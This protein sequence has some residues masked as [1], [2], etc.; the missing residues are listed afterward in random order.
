MKNRNRNEPEIFKELEQLCSSPGYIHAIAYFCFRDNVIKY[1]LGK[2]TSEDFLQQS[3]M[4]KLIRTEISTLIGLACKNSIDKELQLPEITQ[5]YIDQTEALLLELHRSMVSSAHKLFNPLSDDPFANGTILREAIFYGGESAYH[6]QY[7]DFSALK[8]QN[9]NQ[10]LVAN[11]GFY[12]EQAIEI[13]RAIETIQCTKLNNTHQLLSE[14]HPNNWSLLENFTF[15]IEEIEDLTGISKE[16]VRNVIHSFIAPNDIGELTALDDFNPL[17]AYPIIELS[18]D[19]YLLF[20]SYS[21]VEALYET[22]FY[23]FIEKPEYRNIAMSNRGKFAEEFSAERF[24]I[25]FGKHRIFK[26]VSII[27]SKNNVAGEI[28][29]LVTYANRAIVL[30]AKSKKLTIEA[31]KGNDLCLKNDFKKAVQDAYDQA[32]S[33]SK[34]LI[35][36]EFQL[37][38]QQGNELKIG[39]KFQEIY[40]ICIVSDNYPALSFQARQFLIFSETEIIKPPFVMDVFFLDVITEILQSPLQFLSYINRRVLYGDKILATHEL[41]IFSYHL[42]RNLWLYEDYS[43]MNIADDICADLDL[44]MFTRRDGLPGVRTPQGIL[45]NYRGSE[46]DQMVREIE[47]LEHPA[48]IDLGFMLLTLS[49]DTINLINDGISHLSKLTTADGKAHDLTLSIDKG[50]TGLTIHCNNDPDFIA[51]PRLERHCRLRKYDQKAE[52]WFGI[53]IK[54]SK[55]KMRFGFNF[56]EKWMQS[57]EMDHLV[58]GMRKPHS[59][60]GLNRVDFHQLFGKK[61]LG[62]NDKCSCGSGKKYKKCCLNK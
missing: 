22:P 16:I 19:N 28:D 25:V 11:K 61:E 50:R 18:T 23:W 8:Y 2:A 62:R 30:Q 44:A 55:P 3:S 57:D 46:F 42:K 40:P 12:I 32:Y 33:C 4:E 9:D 26:N 17:N 51:G 21:L 1:S 34:M 14:K 52:K 20:Q 53:C 29:V 24:K 49:G 56:D 31:R 15:S 41:A 47:F 60:N 6:F 36:N 35:D 59:L 48:T 39:R 58:E 45:T 27:D 7:R 38:D 5:K 10:W 37:F 54:P 43:M 13:V